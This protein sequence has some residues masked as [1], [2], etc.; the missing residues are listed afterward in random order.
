MK[1]VGAA[2]TVCSPCGCLQNENCDRFSSGLFPTSNSPSLGLT[3]PHIQYVPRVFLQVVKQ[4]HREADHSPPSSAEVKNVW[5]LTFTPPI[6]LHGVMVTRRDNFTLPFPS[7]Q[8]LKSD[9]SLC[10][11]STLQ[12]HDLSFESAY[13]KVRVIVDTPGS[14]AS[15]SVVPGGSQRDDC[16]HT[17]THTHTDSQ[18]TGTVLK[19]RFF[20]GEHG[21]SVTVHTTYRIHVNAIFRF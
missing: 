2:Q 20:R 18:L 11:V 8:V 9:S 7:S 4:L 1:T 17:H 13:C 10:D 19:F 16:F 14:A 6:R 3:Q 15:V 12:I 21:H 5:S